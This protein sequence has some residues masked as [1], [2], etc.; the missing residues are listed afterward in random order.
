VISDFFKLGD[1]ISKRLQNCENAEERFTEI[2]TE[3]L[4]DSDLL[5]RASP[6][7]VMAW[8]FSQTEKPQQ[9]TY[10]FGEPSIVV[11]RS[12]TFYIQVLF[13]TDGTTSIHQH[14]FAG[15]FGVLAG[16]S[17]HAGYEFDG[18][19]LQS[20]SLQVGHVC[21][22]SAELLGQGDVRPIKMKGSAHALFHLDRP[23]V[24]VVV[25]TPG[26]S[27]VS[28][29]NYIR[30]FLAI[31][32]FYKPELPTVQMRM[33]ECLYKTDRKSFWASAQALVKDSDPWM[34]Y[35]ILSLVHGKFD[36]GRPWETFLDAARERNAVL[37]EKTLACLRMKSCE[38]RVLQL[39]ASVH[40]AK[41]RFFLALL[42]NVPTRAIVYELIGK[43]FPSSDPESL[44]LRWLGEIFSQKRVGLRLTPLS[45]YLL[46]LATHDAEFDNAK[47][48][49]ARFMKPAKDANKLKEVWDKLLQVDFLKP[50][51]TDDAHRA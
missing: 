30:P 40:D 16:S 3:E 29:Y 14:S 32:P 28:Q 20:S 1:S 6:E 7:D 25:R 41:H 46:K 2:A 23:S 49:L 11:Y 22:V 12:E 15:A 43:R 8:I 21:F 19:E 50:L 13:W 33:L 35:Q 37:T 36:Y 9:D 31:D 26:Y 34:L 48:A 27:E 38:Q 44:A 4:T 5:K 39:R 24:S 45:V 51:F 17:L 18:P 47:G 42:L 10:E